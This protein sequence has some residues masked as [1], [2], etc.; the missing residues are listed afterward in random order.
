MYIT[1]V[2]IYCLLI[3]IRCRKDAAVLKNC[4]TFDGCVWSLH[5]QSF[6]TFTKNEIDENI[7]AR[8]DLSIL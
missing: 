6:L 2:K 3:N 7:E 1:L 8:H 5:L 4:F